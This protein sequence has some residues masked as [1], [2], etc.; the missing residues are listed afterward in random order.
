[1]QN[2]R[3]S[4]PPEP[5]GTQQRPKVDSKKIVTLDEIRWM[6]QYVIEVTTVERPQPSQPF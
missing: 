5:W 2:I 4:A 3:G 6:K 1:M